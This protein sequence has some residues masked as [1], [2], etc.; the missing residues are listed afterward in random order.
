MIAKEINQISSTQYDNH[1][2]FQRKIVHLSITQR[3]LT[4]YGMKWY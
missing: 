2:I 3:E 1:C 4:L